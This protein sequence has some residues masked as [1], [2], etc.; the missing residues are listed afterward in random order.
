MMS[1]AADVALYDDAYLQLLEVYHEAFLSAVRLRNGSNVGGEQ[2]PFEEL[3]RL[4]KIAVLDLCR[5]AICACLHRETPQKF[6]SR[7]AAQ[8]LDI[9]VGEWRRSFSRLGWMLQLAEE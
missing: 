9:Q 8:P 2:W 7:A 3:L 4:F 6:R 5:W 1:T